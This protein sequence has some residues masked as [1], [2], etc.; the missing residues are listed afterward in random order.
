MTNQK[1][2][3]PRT[4][5]QTKVTNCYLEQYLSAFTTDNL[6]QWSKFLPWAEYHYNTSE[7]SAIHMTPFEAVCG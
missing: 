2:Y 3:H 5:G 4:N 6:K 7:H 1:N